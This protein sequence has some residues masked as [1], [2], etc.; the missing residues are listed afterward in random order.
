MKESKI[1]EEKKKKWDNF[2]YYY[3]Y[4]VL[5]GLFVVV[6]IVVF[7]KD[8]MAKVDYD[9]HV[10][11]VGRYAI[12]D[13]DKAVLQNWFEEQG[14]DL[15][16]DGEIHV[17]IADY[18][19]PDEEDANFDPQIYAASQTKFMVDIQEGTSMIFF[20]NE[21][22][23]EKLKEMDVFPEKEET[24]EVKECSG[25]QEMGSPAFMEDMLVTMRLVYDDPKSKDKEEELE[26]YQVCKELFEKFKGKQ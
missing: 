1:S 21:T 7:V 24:E 20:L 16:G 5:A 15:N 12:P 6:C 14:K 18:C 4:H 17:D 22:N 25:F 9:Y 19:L 10:S 3:K 26:Y 8:M 11:V 13:E 2:W 23:Y